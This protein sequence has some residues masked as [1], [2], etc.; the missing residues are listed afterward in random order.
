MFIQ[1]QNKLQ[2]T[3]SVS[4]DFQSDSNDYH[5]FFNII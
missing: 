1:H 4:K 3:I 5:T 2:F